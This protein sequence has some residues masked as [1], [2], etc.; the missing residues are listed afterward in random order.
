[1]KFTATVISFA[2]LT[3]VASAIV[4]R[5]I[6][7]LGFK[8]G[9]MLFSLLSA[10]SG[11]LVCLIIEIFL[12]GFPEPIKEDPNRIQWAIVFFSQGMLFGGV[13]GVAAFPIVVYL[14]KMY[15][16]RRKNSD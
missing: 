8:A 6:Q 13:I 9:V 4:R 10:V 15:H 14:D 12:Y 7:G 5:A 3:I 11:G 16:T 1:M 2:I